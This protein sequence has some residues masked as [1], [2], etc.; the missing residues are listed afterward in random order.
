M[1]IYPHP[2]MGKNQMPLKSKLAQD[3]ISRVLKERRQERVFYQEYES[4]QQL[5]EEADKINQ[6]LNTIDREMDNLSSSMEKE[7]E[8]IPEVVS[9]ELQYGEYV[10]IQNKKKVT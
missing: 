10:I 5:R 4:K 3:V 6:H 9:P 1:S 2:K 7:K 8:S